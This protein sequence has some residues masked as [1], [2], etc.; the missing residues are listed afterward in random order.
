[1]NQPTK[2]NNLLASQP[3]GVVFLAE[4]MVANGYSWH[5]QK[6]YREGSW[7][8]SIGIGAMIRASTKITYEGA[9][10]ALQNQASQTIHPGGL[11]ALAIL[12]K[13]HNLEEY[14]KFIYF[15]GSTY[16][17]FPVWFRGHDWG[18][19]YEYHSTL[20]LPPDEGLIDHETGSFSIKISSPERAIME[21]LH[22]APIHISIVECYEVMK[23]LN[24]LP[25]KSVQNLLEK[26]KS[27]KVKRLFLYLAEKAGHAWFH[28]LDLS[29]IRTGKG[30][31]SIT[32]NGV[33]IGK[34]QM[35]VP[36]EIANI[37]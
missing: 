22:I 30:K 27:F 19:D 8:E 10:Y 3:P 17:T 35:T 34:Y 20:F 37:T 13:G 15:Y 5:L 4:W 25:I 32:R 23:C 1:M 11:S 24:N 18:I 26:C 2:I 33:Y 14:T 29:R 31:R 9:I 21:C 36:K 28:K 6:A 7:L 16:E 12:G